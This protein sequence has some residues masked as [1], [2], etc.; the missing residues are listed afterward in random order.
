MFRHMISW[1]KAEAEKYQKPAFHRAGFFIF[2]P[3]GLGLIPIRADLI[4]VGL[5]VIPV[6]LI[7]IPIR[8]DL[9][10]IEVLSGQ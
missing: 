9:I 6:R 8:I 5:I 1:R 4:P 7:V 10:P 2:I 3:V